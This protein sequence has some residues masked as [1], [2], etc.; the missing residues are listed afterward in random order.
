M[1]NPLIYACNMEG[2]KMAKKVNRLCEWK[3]KN[4]VSHIS[5]GDGKE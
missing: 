1:T 5:S 4:I 2:N 3:K